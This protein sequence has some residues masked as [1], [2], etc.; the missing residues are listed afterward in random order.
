MSILV[1]STAEELHNGGRGDGA[2]RWW[3]GVHR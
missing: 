2:S 3:S 1:C